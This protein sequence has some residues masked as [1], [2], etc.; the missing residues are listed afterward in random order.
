M[1]KL[2]VKV[3]VAIAILIA[4]VL[5]LQSFQAKPVLSKTPDIQALN[6]SKLIA[7]ALTPPSLVRAVLGGRPVYVLHVTR[8][9]DTVLVRCYPTYEPTIT[10]R[11]MGGDSNANAQREGVMTCRPSA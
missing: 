4:L 7:T 5:G 8:S 2:S 3:S 6:Q 1:F 11:P 10:V 9:E